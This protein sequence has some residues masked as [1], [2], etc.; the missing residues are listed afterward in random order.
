M[1]ALVYSRGVHWRRDS[2]LARISGH[3]R[4]AADTSQVT[5]VKS[6]EF[7]SC[8]AATAM[9]LPWLMISCSH[10]CLWCR[11]QSFLPSAASLRSEHRSPFLDVLESRRDEDPSVGWGLRG[12]NGS[13]RQVGG[14]VASLHT[15]RVEGKFIDNQLAGADKQGGV[16]ARRDWNCN[17][18]RRA[19]RKQL[20]WS[21][22]GAK[23]CSTARVINRSKPQWHLGRTVWPTEA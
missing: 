21:E 15:A 11:C 7:L 8:P 19:G 10:E 23:C 14:N 6:Q 5:G 4:S 16:A 20:L 17:G 9:I 12:L 3:R 1:V 22:D 13:G 18:D 2:L